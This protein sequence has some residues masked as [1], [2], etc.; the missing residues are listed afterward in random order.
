MPADVPADTAGINLGV[1]YGYEIMT[2]SFGLLI[3][4]RSFVRVISS[5]LA[6]IIEGLT[7]GL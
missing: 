6:R 4:P 1:E 5:I 3:D 2:I 7:V